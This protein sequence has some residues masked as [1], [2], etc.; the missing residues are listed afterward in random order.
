[1]F[2]GYCFKLNGNMV[3]GAMAS[4]YLLVRVG[5]ELHAMAIKKPGAQTM[6][7]GGRD[8]IGFVEVTDDIENEDSLKEWVD[9]AWDFVKTLP[10]KEDKPTAKKAAPSAVKA[11]A[12][13]TVSKPA[14]PKAAAKKAAATKSTRKR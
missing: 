11:P 9:F 13:K 5:S 1:M 2:G 8:M 4:G 7:H 12:K 6:H 14:S 10:P 3:C